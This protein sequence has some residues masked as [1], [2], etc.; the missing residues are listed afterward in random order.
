MK[1]Y[2]ISKVRIK[3]DTCCGQYVLLI[4]NAL[5]CPPYPVTF[6]APLLPVSL[7]KQTPMSSVLKDFIS[8]GTA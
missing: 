7:V 4:N 6:S 5:S 3:S 8:G 2:K 1:F